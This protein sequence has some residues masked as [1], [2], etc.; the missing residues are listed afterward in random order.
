MCSIVNFEAFLE[1][2]FILIGMEYRHNRKI[3]EK[4]KYFLV[5]F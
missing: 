5:H 1:K 4:Y 2:L 3:I